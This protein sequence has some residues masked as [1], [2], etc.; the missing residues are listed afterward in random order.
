[1]G[2]LHTGSQAEAARLGYTRLSCSPLMQ[3][4]RP[5]SVLPLACRPGTRTQDPVPTWATTPVHT[6]TPHSLTTC[7]AAGS[8]AGGCSAPLCLEPWGA[9]HRP[10]SI[11]GK[12]SV[13]RPLALACSSPVCPQT[14]APAPPQ[15]LPPIIRL[16]CPQSSGYQHGP[17]LQRPTVL[18]W[19]PEE[20]LTGTP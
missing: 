13:P 14:G 10:L 18:L 11:K 17:G 8:R 15:G 6:T 19:S 5:V 7:S 2:L 9:P 1:M 4:P 3:G 16:L 12:A 20:P